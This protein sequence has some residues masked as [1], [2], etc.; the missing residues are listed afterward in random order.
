MKQKEQ[1]KGE[2]QK[3]RND[4]P[5]CKKEKGTEAKKQGT[6]KKKKKQGK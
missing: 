5:K 4:M 3:G 2:E 6:M 1:R